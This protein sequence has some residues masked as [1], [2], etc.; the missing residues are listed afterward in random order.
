MEL[1]EIAAGLPLAA[2]FAFASGVSSVREGRRRA[3]LNEALHELRRPLQ[4]LALTAP[5]GDSASDRSWRLAAAA[6]ER[7]EREIN[8]EER[9]ATAGSVALRP[10]A[11]AAVERWR[12][13]AEL[14]GRSLTMRWEGASAS[15]VGDGFDISQ[16]LDNLI[17]NG[18]QHGTGEIRLE[19]SC[20]GRGIRLLVRDDGC[21]ARR[22]AIRRLAWQPLRERLSGRRRHGH[23]LRVVRR[24]AT[25]LGGTFRLCRKSGGT[26]AV[27]ELPLCPEGR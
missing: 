13:R 8:G 19:V 9:V 16:A 14:D 22:G 15:V 6:I 20:D 25:G 5:V 1:A 27:L 2:S 17:T 3:A 11:E 21:G 7:L 26:A 4:A 18:I 24:T 10:L 23:G 12:P